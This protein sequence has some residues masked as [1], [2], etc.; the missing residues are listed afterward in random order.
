MPYLK[1]HRAAIWN[2]EKPLTID[3]EEK[4][5][6]KYQ[7]HI[8]EQHGD[9]KLRL[10]KPYPPIDWTAPFFAM[11]KEDFPSITLK[12]E[13][14]IINDDVKG[15]RDWSGRPVKRYKLKSHFLVLDDVDAIKFKLIYGS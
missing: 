5:D 14:R 7:V 13:D 9:L 4:H 1:E 2:P 6:A 8:I 12:T 11:L 3:W 15:D 10:I